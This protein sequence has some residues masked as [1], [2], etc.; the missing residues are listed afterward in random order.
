M[1]RMWHTDY[2]GGKTTRSR[3]ERDTLIAETVAEAAN[4]GGKQ[5]ESVT[6]ARKFCYV[7]PFITGTISKTIDEKHDTSS[8]KMKQKACT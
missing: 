5:Q 2:S 8:I 7:L 4:Y 1:W 3:D 6:N